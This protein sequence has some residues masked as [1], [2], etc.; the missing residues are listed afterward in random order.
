MN[1]RRRRRPNPLIRVGIA[2]LVPALLLWLVWSWAS[3]R[4]DAEDAAVVPPPPTT[5]VPPPAP[6]PPLPTPLLSFRRTPGVIARQLNVEAFAA[7]VQ[8]LL[9]ALNQRSCLAVSVDSQLV[10]VTSPEVQ[11][12]P[13]STQKLI[14]AAV[15]LDVL[16]ADF[17]YTTSVVGPAPSRG[18][19]AGDIVVVGGGDPL[20]TASDYP[21]ANDQ[22]P[23]FNVTS[24]DSLADA[25]VAAGVTSI[26]GSVIGDASRYDDEYFAP[27]WG[28][29][30]AVSEAGPYDALM[31]NDARQLGD[32]LKA[33][34]PAL[35]A[36][37]EL[38][39][40]LVAR[41]VSIGGDAGVGTALAGTAEIASVQS[42]PLTDVIAE[43]LA[44]SDNNTAE[45]MLK[46]IGYATSGVG[47]REAG[48]AVARE[49]MASWGVAMEQVVL[50]DGSGL[51]LE[52]RLTCSALLTLLQRDD[53]EGP[54][55]AGLAVAGESGTLR[56]IFTDSAVAGRLR[57][58]TGTLNNP[59][60][61]ADPPAVK[62]LAG[63][64]PVE[65]G[66]AVEY[67]LVLNGPTISDQSEYRALWDQL[68]AVLD[69]YPSGVTPAQI[70]PR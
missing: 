46:E 23:P 53:V 38:R 4:A 28:D 15:A 21:I 64:L 41:N 24:L 3:G 5:I 25:I 68:A 60:F 52:N 36:A 11:I 67:A 49:R 7:E 70:G 35:G 63:Y 32:P 30:V 27:G 16:G 55:G 56:E 50:S 65:G 44:N 39:R 9:G 43:M 1:R 58:K 66:G 61:N 40:L 47:T 34:D 8:E 2:S 22:Y 6:G 13:A 17:R 51:S 59:P 62:A 19:V 20:L 48:L 26:Q 69:S 45:L 54:I 33:N 57:G 29:G 42:A 31:A 37:R 10:G 14:V 18:V 12:I